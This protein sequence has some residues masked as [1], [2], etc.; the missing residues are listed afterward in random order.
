MAPIIEVSEEVMNTLDPSR[1]SR[2]T[3]LEN[4]S[5]FDD[6]IYIPSTKLW[7]AK[8][9]TLQ[10][11]NW[12]ET[13]EELKKQ[14]LRMQTPLEF[15]EFLKYTRENYSDIYDNITAVRGS[16][17]AEWIDAYFEKRGNSMYILTQNKTKA[18]KLDKDTLMEDKQIDLKSWLSN[19]TKQGLPKTNTKKGNLYYWYPRADSVVGFDAGFVGF[20]LCCD[21]YP[22]ITDSYLGVFAVADAI[23][24]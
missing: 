18:E 6:F 17:I 13:Q 19:P 16:C 4:K 2:R 8:Q 24:R 20:G 23:A 3:D 9:R 10:E 15:V 21:R 5:N 22:S 14:G 1:Y 12:F 11:K 7:T